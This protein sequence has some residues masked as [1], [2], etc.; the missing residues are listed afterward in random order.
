LNEKINEEIEIP[1]ELISSILKEATKPEMIELYTKTLKKIVSL[2]IKRYGND[3]VKILK[4]SIEKEEWF[5]GIVLSTAY[6]EGVGRLVL[7]ESLQDKISNKR[8]KYYNLEQIIILL[9]ASGNID[10]NIY[11]LM[12]EV[13]NYRNNL[14]HI[15]L[16]EEVQIEP[17]TAGKK[18]EKAIKCI[19]ALFGKLAEIRESKIEEI[20]EA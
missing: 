1:K 14:V 5:K 4:D 10:Q 16:Y 3:P 15:E 2:M 11:S 6:F 8:F 9:F 18:I 7:E 17:K 13:K 12:I 19:Q 20:E